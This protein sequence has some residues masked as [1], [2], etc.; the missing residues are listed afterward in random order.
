MLKDP[1][2]AVAAEHLGLDTLDATSP[3]VERPRLRPLHQVRPQ[4]FGLALYHHWIQ[5]A[6]VEDPADVAVGVMGDEHPPMR[7][8]SLDPAGNVDRVAGDRALVT[9]GPDEPE[10]HRPGV[11]TDPHSD[12]QTVG[13]RK[14]LE[15]ITQV[16]GGPHRP[17]RIVFPRAAPAPHPHHGVADVL[18]DVASALLDGAIDHRPQAVH[19][20]GDQLG[21]HPLGQRREPRRVGKQHRRLAPTIGGVGQ[22]TVTIELRPQRRHGHIDYRVGHRTAKLL[23][24]SDR[25]QH[26]LPN[27]HRAQ[28]PKSPPQPPHATFAATSRSVEGLDPSVPAEREARIQNGSPRSPLAP[29]TGF[30]P[31]PP[32]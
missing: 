22:W 11:H 32:P 5:R 6:H 28:P 19:Q 23:L 31:V 30:E 27:H 15:R 8:E 1:E 3:K 18:V 14:S 29:P 12:R 16:K 24:S 7:R 10:Q 26:L 4:R 25:R 9:G 20:T 13:R 2:L 21:V 17:L